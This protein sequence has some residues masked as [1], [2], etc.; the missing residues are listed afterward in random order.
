MIVGENQYCEQK[1]S[2]LY[3]EPVLRYHEEMQKLGLLIRTVH[4][5]F[6]S[7]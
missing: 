2:E 3:Q 1:V 7:H 6:V 5:V 4:C